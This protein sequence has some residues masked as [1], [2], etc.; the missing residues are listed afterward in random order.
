VWLLPVELMGGSLAQ[1]TIP[2]G[3]QGLPHLLSVK[4]PGTPTIYIA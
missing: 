1:G 4:A 3:A 2:H